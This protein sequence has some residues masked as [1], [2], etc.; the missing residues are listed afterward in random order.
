MRQAAAA[1]ARTLG[2]R[3][4]DVL[5]PKELRQV[6]ELVRSQWNATR[7]ID[8][9]DSRLRK[10]IPLV[11]YI[12]ADHPQDWLA[13]DTELCTALLDW[14]TAK[15]R[16][17]TVAALLRAFLQTYPTAFPSFEEMRTHLAAA[18][19]N[20]EIAR[21]GTF[22]ALCR[23]VGHLEEDGPSRIAAALLGGCAQ[24]GS[25]LDELGLSGALATS[26]FTYA[27]YE[28]IVATLQH[29][30]AADEPHLIA[31]TVSLVENDNGIVRFNYPGF[32]V[33]LVTALLS[34]LADREPDSTTRESLFKF[35][36]RLFGDPR[37]RDQRW[38]GVTPEARG[39]M[40]R[41][42]VQESFDVYFKVLD[43]TA[44]DRHWSYRRPFWERY[45]QRGNV[46]DAWAVLGRAA[47]EDAHAHRIRGD[48]YGVMRSGDKQQSALLMRIR[49]SRGVAVVAEWSHNGSCR[50]W[51]DE[52]KYVPP[53][54]QRQ[55]DPDTLRWNP[56]IQV[57]HHGSETGRWQSTIRSDLASRFGIAP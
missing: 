28:Q 32:R 33:R 22:V 54:Y 42:L 35:C 57:A 50:I 40:V 17:A 51:S 21:P 38:A 24:T 16:T 12:P 25:T 48:S 10:L 30:S 19:N 29:R 20:P 56:E 8:G 47:A 34:P 27:A 43:R 3:E 31:R 18:L 23:Q 39:V 37:S 55:Y 1:V 45:L 13:H 7:S 26:A 6:F 5:P 49:G 14:A 2:D 4:G 41:W 9:V 52:R 36:L 44:D 53:F 11:L 15:R 46:I